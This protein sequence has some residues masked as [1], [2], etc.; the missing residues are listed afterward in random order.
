MGTLDLLGVEWC[1]ASDELQLPSVE[2]QARFINPFISKSLLGFPELRAR[3]LATAFPKQGTAVHAPG[4]ILAFIHF[5]S[6]FLRK[7]GVV[8]EVGSSVFCLFPA[9][10]NWRQ[11]SNLQSMGRDRTGRGIWPRRCVLHH[12]FLLKAP[13]L[14]HTS[15]FRKPIVWAMCG[16]GHHLSEPIILLV[17][18]P[19]SQLMR[20]KVRLR[21]WNEAG[22]NGN[23]QA[24]YLCYVAQLLLF[25]F[26]VLLICLCLFKL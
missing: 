13:V 14:V 1:V 9:V 24:L 17:E 5:T 22:G 20:Y 12:T 16:L 8:A 10:W 6:C 4:P 11:N 18:V 19:V 25:V 3:V 15:V 21:G 2:Q 26:L 7:R 23:E